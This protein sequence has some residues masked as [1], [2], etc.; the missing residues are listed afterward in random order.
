[1][2]APAPAPTPAADESADEQ[3]R[4]GDREY[5]FG[6]GD[7]L[8]GDNIGPM[9]THIRAQVNKTFPSMVLIRAS[10]VDRIHDQAKEM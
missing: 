5:N 7:T 10:F 6:I 1:M 8:E 2:L 9:D 4:V 3:A